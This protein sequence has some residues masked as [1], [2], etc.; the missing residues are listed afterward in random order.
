MTERPSFPS[1]PADYK[2]IVRF[3]YRCLSA[4]NYCDGNSTEKCL[5]CL[6]LKPRESCVVVNAVFIMTKDKHILKQTIGFIY[7]MA[8]ELCDVYFDFIEQSKL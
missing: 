2:I 4:R 7:Y 6:G 5:W 8:D 1:M 3:F